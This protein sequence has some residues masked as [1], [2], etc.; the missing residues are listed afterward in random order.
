MN[1]IEDYINDLSV[2]D[3]ID[4]LSDESLMVV[5]QL[6]TMYMKNNADTYNYLL[7]KA[8]TMDDKA[9]KQM[10]IGTCKQSNIAMVTIWNQNLPAIQEVYKY[11]DDKKDD[12]T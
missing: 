10:V 12:N 9:F 7:D 4:K 11:L 5:Y 8:K 3:D 1:N 6:L 2:I